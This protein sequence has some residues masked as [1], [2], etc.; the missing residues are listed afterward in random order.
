MKSIK[1]SVTTLVVV[2]LILAMVA[3]I[4]P[5]RAAEQTLPFVTLKVMLPGSA[6]SAYEEVFA[7]IN[8]K[9]K[10]EINAEVKFEWVAWGDY[11]T[12]LT[13]LAAAGDSSFDA[14]FDADWFGFYPNAQK[15]M[16]MDIKPYFEKYA[17]DIYNKLTPIQLKQITVNGKMVAVPFRMPKDDRFV[18]LLREDLREKYNIPAPKSLEDMLPFW[19]A[20][21]ENEQGISPFV[22][23]SLSS[24]AYVYGPSF[25]YFTLDSSN[26]ELVYKQDDPTLKLIPWEQT[27]AFKTICTFMN[28]IYEA[29]YV[30][31]DTLISSVQNDVI[32]L[33]QN[34][35]AASCVHIFA[36]E[37]Y[38]NSVCAATHPDWKFKVY[39]FYDYDAP[40]VV[41]PN[42]CI[43][44]NANGKNPERTLMF[45]NWIAKNQENYDLM[46]Y[47][48]K[49]KT[50]TLVDNM[51]QPMLD[52]AMNSVYPDWLG[53]WAFQDWDYIRYS[54]GYGA[55]YKTQYLAANTYNAKDTP[56]AGFVLNTD[57]IK[58][59]YA[60][61][62]AIYKDMA[63]AIF[64]GVMGPD[65]YD[66]YIQKQKDA[67]IEKILAEAQMQLDTWRTGN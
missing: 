8:E 46:H 17:P 19:Q 48:I 3:S 26:L 5:A 32:T 61:R 42:Q 28:K 65:L 49:D 13:T 35:A 37:A 24:Y 55:D 22:Q 4:L 12:K 58:T 9:L 41:A 64:Q 56:T 67:G 47:G 43:C 6:P 34:G 44:L 29:G 40:N 1:S 15:E 10:R 11:Q 45:L 23:G 33:M 50:Y 52:S 66:E 18:I 14:L 51:Y 27:D 62:L 39:N 53:N 30:P 54:T 38:L 16:Y 31:K 57:N 7:V 59:E 25:N 60:Q 20:I 63:I 36:E 21:K 2:A